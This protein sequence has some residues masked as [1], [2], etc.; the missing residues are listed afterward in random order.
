[1][2]QSS[3]VKAPLFAAALGLVLLSSTSSGC[4]DAAACD[5]SDD[6]NPPVVY[7]GGTTTEDGLYYSSPWDAAWLHFPGGQRYDLAHDLGFQPQH[8]DIYLSFSENGV[9]KDGQGATVALS[10]GNSSLV[11][12]I[13]ENII[14]IKNDTCSEF[15][16]R[17][18][19]SGRPSGKTD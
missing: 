5:T 7:K 17:V 13:D 6:A 11:Q 12:H 19:A 8:F 16:V 15:W 14:R 10:A 4:I 2:R 3:S 9:G 1:M 18:T